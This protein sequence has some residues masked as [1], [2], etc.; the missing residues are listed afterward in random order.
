MGFRIEDDCVGCDYCINCGKKHIHVHYCDE[1]DTYADEWDALYLLDDKELCIECVKE[2]L[3]SKL[4]DDMDEEL[5]QRCKNEA[6]ILYQYDGE[7]LCE[8]CLKSVLERVDMG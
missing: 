2:H 3:T 7:W 5:C 8:E 4:C 6:N 1:C